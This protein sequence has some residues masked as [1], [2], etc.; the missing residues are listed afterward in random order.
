[1]DATYQYD[2]VCIG[3]GPAGQR[4]A[5]QAAKLGRRV[6]LVERR[7]VVGGVC[8][9]TGTIPSKTFRE[10]VLSFSRRPPFERAGSPRPAGRPAISDLLARVAEVVDREARVIEDQLGRNGIQVL[11]GEAT[12]ADPHTLH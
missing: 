2:L 11:Y 7:Q 5:G 10:A 12:F 3:S 1:M 9:D 8:L 4:A 6:A